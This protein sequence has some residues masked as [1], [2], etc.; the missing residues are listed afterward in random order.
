M[1]RFDNIGTFGHSLIPKYGDCIF[2]SR[3]QML[4]KFEIKDIPNVEI[5]LLLRFF[6]LYSMH[7]YLMLISFIFVCLHLYSLKIII[8]QHFNYLL[9]SRKVS[10][11]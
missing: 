2:S 7:D 6:A 11:K 4:V 9:Q 3:Q 5:K 1:Y 8:K 10:T